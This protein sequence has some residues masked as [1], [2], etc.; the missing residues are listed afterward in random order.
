MRQKTVLDQPIKE[1]TRKRAP[2]S[3]L[4]SL[5]L[6]MLDDIFD[7]EAAARLVAHSSPL[8]REKN[9]N[10]NAKFTNKVTTVETNSTH[11]RGN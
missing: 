4:L 9:T 6:V 11:K 3:L 10:C 2:S 7:S 8:S 5:M 1:Q